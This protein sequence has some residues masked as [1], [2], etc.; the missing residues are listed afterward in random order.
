V[1]N[2]LRFKLALGA[3]LALPVSPALAMTD[4]E[5]EAR[6]LSALKPSQSSNRQERAGNGASK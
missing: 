4:T 5:L 6:M 2:A 3:T 1:K